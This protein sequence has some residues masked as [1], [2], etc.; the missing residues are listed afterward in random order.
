MIQWPMIASCGVLAVLL[1]PAEARATRRIPAFARQFQTSCAMCHTA[2]PKLNPLGEA[3]RLAGYQLPDNR[4]LIR[5]DTGIALGDDGWKDQWPR[6]IWP[7]QIPAIPP[8]SLRVEM[9]AIARRSSTKPSSTSLM[10]P[11]GVY[12]LYASSLGQGLSAFVGA[13]WTRE[14]GLQLGQA[15][16]VIADPLPGLAPRRLNIS[17]GQQFLYP[18]TFSDPRIDRATVTAFDWQGYRASDL[19]VRDRDTGALH[20]SSVAFRLR[21]AQPLIELNGLATPRLSWALGIAQGAG[22]GDED[23]N[24]AKDAMVRLRYKVGGLRLDGAYDGVDG[25]APHAFGQLQDQRS[26]TFETF[27]YLGTEPSVVAGQADRHATVGAAMRLLRGPLDLGAGL[28]WHRDDDPWGL[29]DASTMTS[30]FMKAE[31]QALPWLS[32]F[33]KGER[34]RATGRESRWSGEI[35]RTRLMPGVTGLV[36]PNV[37]CA[38]EAELFVLD[39]QSAALRRQRP[40]TVVARLDFAY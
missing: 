3:F 25:P 34:F 14:R 26:V 31:W 12:L 10:F 5:R 19:E 29:G 32:G 30:A 23:Q 36:R 4:S 24:Q 7:G 8:L 38:I 17:V 33:V 9:G 27:A 20:K 35:A 1:V 22:V 13:V 16:L 40:H 39:A 11:E 28:V 18:F 37:R 21:G 6:A 15:K 2:I